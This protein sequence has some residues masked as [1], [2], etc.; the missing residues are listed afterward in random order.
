[1][2]RGVI[3]VDAHAKHHY[4]FTS[5]TRLHLNHRRSLLDARRTKGSPEIQYH[6]LSAE[7]AEGNL[8]IGILHREIRGIRTDARRMAAAVASEQGG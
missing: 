6:H 8:V 5:E 7:L 1:M 4:T 2:I 3:D